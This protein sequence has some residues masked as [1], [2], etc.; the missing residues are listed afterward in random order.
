MKTL[1]TVSI[2]LA[3]AW[4]SMAQ[5]PKERSVQHKELIVQADA[6]SNAG[7]YKKAVPLYDSAL[8]LV[9]WDVFAYFDAT[10]AALQ[11]GREDKANEFLLKGVEHGFVPS[12]YQDSIYTAFLASDASK[13]FRDQQAEATKKF[14][15][16]ADSATI[17]QLMRLATT[18]QASREG[19][20]SDLRNDSLN[21]EELITICENKD[22]PT[23]HT[24][25]STSGTP[26]LLLWHHRGAEY[27]DSPQW[28]RIIPYIEKAI[29]TGDLDPAFLCM[30]ED[31]SNGEKGIPMQYGVLIGYYRNFPEK[32]YLADRAQM[33]ANRAKVGMGTIEDAAFISGVDLTKVR[34]AE[35]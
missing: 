17:K 25:G 24:V 34:F 31:Y 12:V 22:F 28:K 26:W 14:A 3:I 21:F 30:F 29:D 19:T 8:A 32:L 18:D 11:A 23:A 9:N 27:P 13:P 4:P 7:D 20:P 15:A 10:L 35:P 33:N 6:S 5:T 1:V 2:C 16:H